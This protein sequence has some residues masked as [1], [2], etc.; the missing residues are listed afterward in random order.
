MPGTIA[1]HRVLQCP[2]EK[3]FK[4]FTTPDALARWIAPH[5]FTCSVH[6]IDLRVGGTHKASFTNFTTGNTHSFGGTYLEIVTNELLRYTDDFE[7]PTLHGN[8]IVTVRIL[9]VPCG[10][11]LTIMQEGLP[12]VIPLDVCYLGWQQSLQ[13]LAQLV[14]PNIPD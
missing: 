2:P 4:A 3:L 5:G 10:S 14:E 13:Y 9:A 7:D 6:H 12:D 1:L 11:D 8:I